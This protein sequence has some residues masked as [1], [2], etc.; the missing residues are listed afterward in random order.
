MNTRTALASPHSGFKIGDA[1]NPGP[2]CNV[3]DDADFFPHDDGDSDGD[4]G[5]PDTCDATDDWLQFLEADA[6]VGNALSS[7]DEP[8][9]APEQEAPLADPAADPLPGFPA[10]AHHVV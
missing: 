3:F 10:G 9:P 1:A 2:W 7:D 8:E 4:A 6:A 5:P